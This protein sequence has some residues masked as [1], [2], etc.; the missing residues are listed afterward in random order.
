MP[1]QTTTISRGLIAQ[2]PAAGA[3]A[4]PDAEA[5]AGPDAGPEAGAEVEVA[6]PPEA[7]QLTHPNKAFDTGKPIRVT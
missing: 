5:E 7:S 3:E 1:T 4:G 6:G 2:A